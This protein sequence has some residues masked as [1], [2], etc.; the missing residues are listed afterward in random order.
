MCDT[1]SDNPRGD[2]AVAGVNCGVAR[3][4]TLARAVI[5][6][7]LGA[8]GHRL[9][10][11]VVDVNLRYRRLDTCQVRGAIRAGLPAKIDEPMTAEAFRA[12]SAPTMGAIEEIIL[13]G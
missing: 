10:T 6:D 2:I 8:P 1:R 7:R 4:L 5:V 13:H 9:S 3:R 12:Q 11:V